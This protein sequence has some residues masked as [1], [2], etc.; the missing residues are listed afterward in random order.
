MNPVDLAFTP[1]LEQAG[2]IRRRE[3]SPLELVRVYLERIER[4]NPTLGSFFTV[5][6]EQAIADATAKTE[7]LAGLQS[8]ELPPFFGVPIS[9]KDLTPV[10]GVACSYGVKVLRDRLAT[11]DSGTV[12]RIKQAGFVLLGKTATSE[13]GSTPYTEPHGFPPARNPWN[14]DF[15]PGGS[16]GGA[17]ASVAAGLSPI[18]HG[19][20]GGGSIRGPAFCCGLVGIKPSRGRVSHAPVGDRLNGLSTDGPLAHTVADAAA[21]LDVMAGHTL[22]DPY[23]LPDPDASFLAATQRTLKPLR[24]GFTTDLLPIGSAD[25][26][27]TQ[28]VL[29]TVHRLEALG[30][31]AEPVSLNLTDLAEPLVTVWQTGVDVG[32]PWFLMGKLNRWLLRRSRRRSAGQYLQAVAKMQTAARSLVATL[33][34]FDVV[35]L[36]VFL[37]STIRVGE[38]AKLRPA[39]IFEKV[40]HW[41]APSPIINATGQ[42]AIALPTGFTPAG[43]PIGVQLVG[44]PADE[45]TLIALAA[46]LEAAY[47][48]NQFRPAIAQ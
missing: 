46:Q 19:S 25:E 14:P 30:H 2:L 28:A 37:H 3:I 26:L 8:G 9:I 39:Q 29:E 5:M 31:H 32:V 7:L 42:P 6:A 16:S 35:V 44:R 20:D 1:A 36:P 22:G 13:V 40:V 23:W 15:T 17:A 18:A 10:E 47:P 24:V 4:L 43:L 27:C 11:E 48:C 38:W 34:P 45:E 12:R 33:D 41:V 21:L